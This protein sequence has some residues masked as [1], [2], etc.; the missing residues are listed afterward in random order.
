MDAGIAACR[1]KGGREEEGS[2]SQLTAG[3]FLRTSLK[4]LAVVSWKLPPTSSG[5]S[6][7]WI[8][9]P[10]PSEVLLSVVEVEG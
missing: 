1:E 2:E 9:S 4:T 10:L 7:P 5:G 3:R 8:S 6:V